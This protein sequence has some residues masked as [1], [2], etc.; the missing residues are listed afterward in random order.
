MYL[1]SWHNSSL[2]YH[3]MIDKSNLQQKQ[4]IVIMELER[5]NCVFIDSLFYSRNVTP[6]LNGLFVLSFNYLGSRTPFRLWLVTA[7]HIQQD[8]IPDKPVE[9]CSLSACPRVRN[10]KYLCWNHHFFY[11]RYFNGKIRIVLCNLN[12]ECTWCVEHLL[13]SM[14]K[15][16]DL[17]INMCN[18]S[19][20]C[21]TLTV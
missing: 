9:H 20:S 17:F 2:T 15:Y 16:R 8:L 12:S 13:I 11:P 7:M 6:E 1:N 4:K 19:V 21:M 3:V 14:E 5:V 10:L 18:I